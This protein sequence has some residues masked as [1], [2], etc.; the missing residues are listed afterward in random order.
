[1]DTNEALI[2]QAYDAFNA[3]DIDRVL[4]ILHPDVDWPRAWEGDFVK[5]H[6]QVREYWQRQWQQINPVV[7]PLS[8]RDNEDGRV[9]VLVHQLIED[10]QGKLLSDGLVKHVYTLEA[11]RIS[12]MDIELIG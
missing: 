1:M 12:R 4:S 10:K 7:T 6:E 3:R 5:G 2:K 9:E 11:A 8:F